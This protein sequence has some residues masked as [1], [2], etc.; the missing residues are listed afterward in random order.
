[1]WGHALVLQIVA[2]IAVTLRHSRAN[3]EILKSE[4]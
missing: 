2:A 3:R 4:V 1:M